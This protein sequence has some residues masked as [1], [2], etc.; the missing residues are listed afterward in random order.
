[1]QIHLNGTGAVTGVAAGEQVKATT[2]RAAA[3]PAEPQ[4]TTSLSGNSLAV[5]SLTAQALATA[6]ARA[7][8]VEALRQAVANAAYVVDPALVADAIISAGI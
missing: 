3:Q 2:N 4:D 7:A 5:P 8:K 1:M 6:D